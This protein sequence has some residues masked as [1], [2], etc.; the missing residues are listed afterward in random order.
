MDPLPPPPAAPTP[1]EAV[2]QEAAAHAAAHG[3]AAH[4]AEAQDRL[5]S[6]DLHAALNALAHIPVD[7]PLGPDA[8]HLASHISF[9]LGD[10]NRALGNAAA[11]FKRRPSPDFAVTLGTLLAAIGNPTAAADAFQRAL[12]LNP[13]HLPALSNLAALHSLQGKTDAAIPLY[14]RAHKLAPTDLASAL[15]LANALGATGQPHRGAQILQPFASAPHASDNKATTETLATLGALRLAS[16]SPDAAIPLLRRALATQPHHPQA[17]HNLLHALLYSDSISPEETF[18]A[19]QSWAA[20][21]PPAARPPI[22]DPDPHR[23]LRLAYLS[24]DLHYHPISMFIE[25]LLSAHDPHRFHLTIYSDTLQPDATTARLRSLATQWRDA[26]RLSDPALHAQIRADNID[27]L[28]DLASHSGRNRLAVFAQR[29]APLQLTY[30]AYAFSTGLPAIDYRITDDTLDPPGLTDH[31]HAEQLLRLPTP[32][33]CF[34]PPTSPSPGPPPALT[35]GYITFGSA[36]RL[37]KI[38]PTALNLWSRALTEIPTARLRVIAPELAESSVRADFAARLAQH[39]ISPTR[40]HLQGPLP[41]GHYHAYLGTFDIALDTFP[42]SGGATTCQ[43]LW[44]GVPV[45]T[46]AATTPTSRV[47]A[48][49]LTAAA[50]PD[51]IARSPQ[52]FHHISAS[53]ARDLPRLTH[54]RATLR[55]TLAASPLTRPDLFLPALESELQRAWRALT[56]RP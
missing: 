30:L 45:V 25:P 17:H 33:W 42:F 7:S 11:A 5:A 8:L 39:D 34:T 13:N 19:H 27:I 47:S 14:E 49:A 15:A 46:L 9:R 2:P 48:S 21:L 53:L 31:L 40:A 55:R 32:F 6:A 36:N 50:L 1:Q 38:T 23:P 26:S 41:P 54:L 24:P 29:P 4:W 28:I 56:T 22:R 20:Q 10:P 3:A 18:A 44:A 12:A 35:N 43:L 37:A 16:G 51:L 52:S